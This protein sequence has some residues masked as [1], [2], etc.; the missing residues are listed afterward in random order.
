MGFEEREGTKRLQG[1]V[2]KCLRGKGVRGSRVKKEGN[3][4]LRNGLESCMNAVFD[5]SLRR[6]RGLLLLIR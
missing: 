5:E 2:D 6:R 1:V 3:E 4:V